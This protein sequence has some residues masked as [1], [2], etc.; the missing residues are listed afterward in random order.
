[1]P[2]L[3]PIDLDDADYSL[4][5]D[6]AQGLVAIEQLQGALVARQRV[7]AVAESAVDRFLEADLTVCVRFFFLTGSAP[8]WV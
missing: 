7:T 3:H 5:A 4:A 1:M 8:C 2:R 6:G